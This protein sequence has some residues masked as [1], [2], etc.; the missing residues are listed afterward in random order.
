MSKKCTIFVFWAHFYGAIWVPV[1]LCCSAPWGR[2]GCWIVSA[3][4]CCKRAR[5]DREGR[6]ATTYKTPGAVRSTRQLTHAC[7]SAV[8]LPY[9][10]LS[11]CVGWAYIPQSAPSAYSISP[12]S[13]RRRGPQ[14]GQLIRSLQPHGL[15]E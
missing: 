15:R 2:A 14:R 12:P 8:C 11:Y 4:Q 5:L 13:T 1:H 3:R 7:A 6:R 10:C 9:A